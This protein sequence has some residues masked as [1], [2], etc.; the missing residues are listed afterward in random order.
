M[1]YSSAPQWRAFLSL[2][3]RELKQNLSPGLLAQI[4]RGAGGQFASQHVLAPAGTVADMQEAV[5]QVWSELDW[6]VVEMREAE[7]WL[8]LTHYQAPF[9]V[10]FG[11]ENQAWAGA[12]LEGAYEEWMH[13][14]G[15]DAQLRMTTAGCADVS[16]TMVFLFGK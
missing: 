6:G 12:F 7:D 2:F 10:V 15:A 3:A 14:L 11:T 13:Q 4:A 5:N 9:L 16:G 8:V 1:T